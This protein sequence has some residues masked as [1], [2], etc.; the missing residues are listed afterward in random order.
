MYIG[1]FIQEVHWINASKRNQFCSKTLQK[2][3]FVSLRD[4]EKETVKY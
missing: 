4:V 3:H 2:I 1:S